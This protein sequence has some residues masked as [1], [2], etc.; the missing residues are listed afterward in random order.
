[1]KEDEDTIIIL[2]APDAG[3]N[4]FASHSDKPNV[5]HEA[6]EAYWREHFAEKDYTDA[7]RPFS[8]YRPAYRTASD[9]FSVFY[10][11]G[12]PYDEIESH[13]KTHYETNRGESDVE[14]D[15]ARH[16]VRDAW[17]RLER[18]FSARHTGHAT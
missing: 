5:D 17:R 11:T 18:M 8:D 15:E 14:W 4:P 12:R 2:R 7:N 16:A 10:G 3:E 13:L 6:E 9:L 1:M